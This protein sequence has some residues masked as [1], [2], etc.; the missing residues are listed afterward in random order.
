M[1]VYTVASSY[2]YISAEFCVNSLISVTSRLDGVSIEAADHSSAGRKM[3]SA[4]ELCDCPPGYDGTSCEVS[5]MVQ[6]RS[7]V[8]NCDYYKQPV[9]LCW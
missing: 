5:I 6:T 7:I 1:S 8:L 4:V 9:S 3:A 2:T